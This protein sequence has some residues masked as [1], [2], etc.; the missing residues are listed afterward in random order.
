M[1]SSV[2]S[3]D[4]TVR[5]GD[6]ELAVRDHGGTGPALLLL[7]GAG[8]TLADW[9]GVAAGLTADHRVVA[10][11]LRAHGHS[12]AGSGPWTIPAVLGDVQAV[13]DACGIPD[14]VPVGHSL[15]GMVAALHAE[16]HPHTPAAVNLDGFGQGRPESYVGLE[17]ETVLERLARAHDVS[18]AG[19]GRV[20]PPEGLD[21]VRGYQ[22]AMADQ[23]GF[24]PELLEE[25]LRRSLAE[26]GDGQLVLRPERERAV[27]MLD[28]MDELDMVAVHRRTTRPLL[29]VRAG[30]L[31]DQGDQLAWYDELMAA[32]VKGLD[33]ELAALAAE[34]PSLTVRTVD[35]THAMLLERPRTLAEE[36]RAFVHRL[37]LRS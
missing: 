36:I 34:R 10:M 31:A 2:P 22:K 5:H 33:R 8:R 17:R 29:V 28:A 12:S 23:L 21:A 37:D 13:L 3:A 19:A 1:S 32:Y 35:A 18:R 16:A 4:R 27:E 30:R 14:A 26:T 6:V 15:G 20:F 11:D 9:S 25:G 7:H 24:A